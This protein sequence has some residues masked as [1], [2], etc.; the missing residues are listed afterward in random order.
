M[1]A[2]IGDDYYTS[3]Q[4]A[5]SDASTTGSKTK[6]RLLKDTQEKIVVSEGRDVELDLQGHKVSNVSGSATITVDGA[7]LE[8]DNGI[9]YTKDNNLHWWSLS[10]YLFDEEGGDGRAF[11][12]YNDGGLS[13]YSVSY[14]VSSRPAVSL[15]SGSV[16]T[17]GEGTLE[18]PYIIG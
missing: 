15:K 9:S 13:V 4:N 14:D 2:A 10:P 18:K 1:V 6:V 11:G 17:G 16:I 3:L 8:L 5:I 12:L 7:I